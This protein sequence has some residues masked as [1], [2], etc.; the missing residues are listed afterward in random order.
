MKKIVLFMVSAQEV[1]PTGER[2]NILPYI[3]GIV[4]LILIVAVGWLTYL[5]KKNNK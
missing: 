4:A 3:F 2:T 1:V 5:G